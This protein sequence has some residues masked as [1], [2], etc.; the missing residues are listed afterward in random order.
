MC[1]VFLFLSSISSPGLSHSFSKVEMGDVDSNVE[2]EH[3]G[4]K[5]QEDNQRNRVEEEDSVLKEGQ[6]CRRCEIPRKKKK[7]KNKR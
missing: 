6:S 2:V 3:D 5:I 7:K 1:K 4:D